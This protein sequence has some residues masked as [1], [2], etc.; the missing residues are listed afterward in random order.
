MGNKILAVIENDSLCMGCLHL[1]DEVYGAVAAGCGWD[2]IDCRLK[3]VAR[4]IYSQRRS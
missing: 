1:R 3:R 4:L 2:L